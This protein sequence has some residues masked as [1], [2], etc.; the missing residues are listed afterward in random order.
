MVGLEVVSF[1]QILVDQRVADVI[2]KFGNG[3]VEL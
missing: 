2:L 3:E 1:G